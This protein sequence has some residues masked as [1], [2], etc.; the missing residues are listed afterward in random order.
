MSDQNFKKNALDYSKASFE[1][2]DKE[3]TENLFRI[4]AEE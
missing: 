4:L 1:L 3:Q 2:S